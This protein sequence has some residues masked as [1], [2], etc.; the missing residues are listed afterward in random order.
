MLLL[1]SIPELRITNPAERVV[2]TPP[3]ASSLDCPPAASRGE[4]PPLPREELAVG[5]G[6][7]VQHLLFP[8]SP[9]PTQQAGVGGEGGGEEHRPGGRPPQHPHYP[10]HFLQ[11]A[12]HMREGREGGG[13]G[14]RHATKK[15][16]THPEGRSASEIIFPLVL[17]QH[18]ML[19]QLNQHQM[20]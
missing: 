10:V 5:G 18:Q 16:S 14:A 3:P 6:E 12:L 7:V 1:I 9:L 11:V 17:N 8:P 2:F 20:L 4:L 13:G 19:N 15:P